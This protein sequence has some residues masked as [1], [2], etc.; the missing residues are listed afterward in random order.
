M[1]EILCFAILIFVDFNNVIV[2]TYFSDGINRWYILD[3]F[4]KETVCSNGPLN[5]KSGTTLLSSGS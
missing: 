2:L 5:N 3:Q 1:G 4:H